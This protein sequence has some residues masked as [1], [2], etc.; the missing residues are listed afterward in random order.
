MVVA[1]FFHFGEYRPTLSSQAFVDIN[2][3]GGVETEVLDGLRAQI[4]SIV[5]D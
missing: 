4:S 2:T 3:T 5:I 1:K